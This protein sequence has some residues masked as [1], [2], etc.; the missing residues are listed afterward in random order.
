MRPTLSLNARVSTLPM[1]KNRNYARHL[2]HQVPEGHPIFLTWNWKGAMPRAAFEAFR[3]ARERLADQPARP[4]ETAADRRRRERKL[5]FVM[6]DRLLD[7]ATGGPMHL[8]DP[9]AAQ[10]SQAGA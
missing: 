3:R 2:P 7:G 6:A 5:V 9:I 4:G 1:P 10:G 8:K